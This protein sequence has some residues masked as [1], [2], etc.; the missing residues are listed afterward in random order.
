MTARVVG[1]IRQLDCPRHDVGTS[2]DPAASTGAPA[3]AASPAPEA[4]RIAARPVGAD[5]HPLDGLLR[6]RSWRGSG[7]VGGVYHKS[8]PRT[9]PMLA[10]IL[11]FS[12]PH[13][14]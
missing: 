6:I 2:P 9:E 8:S 12:R 1:V 11:G 13:K 10:E 14:A 7:R 4:T 3:G 5:T